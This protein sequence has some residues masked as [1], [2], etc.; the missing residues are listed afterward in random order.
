MQSFLIP[1]EGGLELSQFAEGEDDLRSCPCFKIKLHDFL[2]IGRC[3]RTS[4]TFTDGTSCGHINGECCVHV[5]A[6]NESAYKIKELLDKMD[7]YGEWT[8][9]IE[10][11]KPEANF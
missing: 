3:W 9:V 8:L 11:Y 10:S 2:A 7:W 4:Y 1:L 6:D 5:W